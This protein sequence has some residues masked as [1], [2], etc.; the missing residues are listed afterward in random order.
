[1][2]RL[3]PDLKDL[4]PGNL[5]LPSDLKVPQPVK[6]LYLDLRDRSLLPLVALIVVATAA[7]PFLLSDGGQDEAEPI[8][9]QLLAPSPDS[10]ATASASL[11]VVEAQPGLRDYRKRLKART[12]TDPF[13]QRY[14]KPITKGAELNSASAT[15]DSQKNSTSETAEGKS[16][17][18]PGGGSGGGGGAAPGGD[19]GSGG[20]TPDNLRVY[21]FTIDVQISHTETQPDG[22]T[23]MGPPEV[24][25]GVRGPQPLP[26]KQK[27]VVTYLGVKARD[28]GPKA[29][30]LVSDD[31]TGVFGEAKCVSGIER[32]ELLEVQPGFPELFEYGPDGQSYKIKIT[33]IDIVQTGRP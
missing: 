8:P 28:D 19:G 3:G 18:D 1:V 13:E 33:D 24:R 20:E 22:T 23:K 7:V 30:L 6:D 25:K 27:P 14:T 11:S 10:G 15:T 32:C 17:D 9:S 16:A 2:K 21:T 4:R 31:V 26:G 12:A 29:L 5:K